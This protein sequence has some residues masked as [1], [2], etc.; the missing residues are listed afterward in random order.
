MWLELPIRWTETDRKN[1][2]MEDLLNGEH[3]VEK[4]VFNYGKLVI[5]AA[6]IGP[7]YDLD[8]NNIMIND[9]L[10][11]IYCVTIPLSQFRKILTE[12]TGNAI[13]T[14]TVKTGDP[15]KDAPP[16]RAKPQSDND[17]ILMG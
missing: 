16:T 5:D 4:T 7:Y 17:D 3:A 9:K 13:M 8:A 6:D 10:G 2:K 14:I 12:V 15:V 1:Q 11:K